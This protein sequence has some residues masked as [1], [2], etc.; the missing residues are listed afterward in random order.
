M[1]GA[2]VAVITGANSGIGLATAEAL[3]VEGHRLF[4]LC[5]DDEAGSELEARLGARFVACDMAE[6]S[7]IA[8]AAETVRNE[9]DRVDWLINNAGLYAPERAETADGLELTFAVNHLGPFRLT[10]HLAR[11]LRDGSRVI[12]LAS[13]SHADA[14]LDLDDLSRRRRRYWGY[15]AYADSKLGNVLFTRELDRRLKARGAMAC[16]VHPG[17][18]GTGFAQDAPGL[19]HRLFVLAK[20]LMR[21]PKKGA[22]TVLW[23]ARHPAPEELR[24]AYLCDRRPRRP[25]RA[26]RD[27]ALSRRLWDESL[28]LAGPLP[29]L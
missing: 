18:V 24:G 10:H 8:A 22:Q 4:L 17:T 26:G 19:L 9:T 6:G 27:D 23:A 15:G 1:T 7:S 21:S 29:E 3:A 16:C 25:S 5:R 14:R 20:P 13:R 2:R 12:G 11:T 28:A